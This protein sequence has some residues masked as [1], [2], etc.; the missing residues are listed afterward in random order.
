MPSLC[1]ARTLLRAGGAAAYP[2]EDAPALRPTDKVAE[3]PTSRSSGSYHWDAE[4]LLS[5][6]TAAL[7][8]APAFT[9]AG[10]AWVDFGLAFAIPLHTHIGFDGIVTDYAPY[11]KFGSVFTAASWALKGLTALVIYG[12]YQFNVNDIGITELVKKW[13]R[14]VVLL[15]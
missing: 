10:N 11:R 1:A 3:L 13:V 12:A 14:T 9:G 6:V 8:V 4:R 7:C 5:V 15:K 2:A